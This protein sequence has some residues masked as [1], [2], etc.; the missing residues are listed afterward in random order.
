M[1]KPEFCC[2]GGLSPFSRL[3]KPCPPSLSIDLGD[4]GKVL[5]LSLDISVK[6][7]HQLQDCKIMTLLVVGNQHINLKILKSLHMD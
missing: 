7:V 4:K 2:E 3:P 6:C 1:I 5:I